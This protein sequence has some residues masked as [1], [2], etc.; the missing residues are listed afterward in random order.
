MIMQDIGHFLNYMSDFDSRNNNEGTISASNL[1]TNKTYEATINKFEVNYSSSRNE[2]IAVFTAKVS[3]TD[4]GLPNTNQES[5]VKLTWCHF[6]GND[7][8]KKT[9][10]ET[11]TTLGITG[12][13]PSQ[14]IVK[15]QN[16]SWDMPVKIKSKK[17]ATAAG[18][19]FYNIVVLGRM[20]TIGEGTTIKNF[21]SLNELHGKAKK[22][23]AQPYK[24]VV[25]HD[26]IPN[27]VDL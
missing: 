6:L 12:E 21:V 2:Y 25:W 11:L 7:V 14:I 16:N 3:G 22:T 8:G 4:F 9:L 10:L 17:S 24:Q 1:L 5:T 19:D 20:K 26:E 15:A 13:T 23:D 18:V 27:P